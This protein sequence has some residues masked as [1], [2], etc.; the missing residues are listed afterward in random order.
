MKCYG[1]VAVV[2][3]REVVQSG[4]GGTGFVVAAGAHVMS[5]TVSRN[6]ATS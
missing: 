6:M 3:P 1:R 2:G 5:S 4:R